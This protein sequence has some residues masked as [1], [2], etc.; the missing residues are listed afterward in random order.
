MKEIIYIVIKEYNDKLAKRQPWYSIK[1]L[2]DDLL[3]LDK[4]V[5]IV[6]SVKEIPVS[7]SGKIIKVFSIKDLF[8]KKHPNHQL[9]YF[10]TFPI[11]SINKFLSMPFKTIYS[12]W[13]DLKRIL[14]VA[15]IP[16]FILKYT[17]NKADH[18]IVISDRSEEYL[19]KIVSTHKYIPFIFNNW[20]NI[21]QDRKNKK[22]KKTIG[23]FGP[24]FL[25]RSFDDIIN[26]FSWL[27]NNGYMY[28]K[29]IITRI[30]REELK[31][32]ADIYLSKINHDKSLKVVKGFLNRDALAKELLDI[33]V[34]I[35]PFKIVMSEL[36]IVVL[37]AL[38]LNIPII[39]TSDSGI[40]LITKNQKNIIVFDNF[41]EDKFIDAIKFIENLKYDDFDNVSKSIKAI[42]KITLELLCQN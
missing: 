3:I 23:Y 5:F 4:E 11:Y 28:N 26:F 8:Y 29:K 33:D 36:P 24:P 34:L 40:N 32:I 31:N 30:E 17:L 38:E 9:I 25:T 20:G 16:S 18:I 37:E 35:L 12:N 22:N 2:Y 27:N 13:S 14:L 42:N 41:E 1:K 39:T 15:C 7:F 21:K 6:S 10:M 19:S